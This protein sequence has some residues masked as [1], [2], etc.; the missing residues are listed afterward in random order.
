MTSTDFLSIQVC[1]I[2]DYSERLRFGQ[3]SSKTDKMPDYLGK[4]ENKF[5]KNKML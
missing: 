2:A 4:F 5:G 1:S 3:I